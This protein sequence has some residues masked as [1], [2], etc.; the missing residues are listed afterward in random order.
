MIPKVNYTPKT[1]ANG[2][3]G[4]REKVIIRLCEAVNTLIETGGGSGT[5]PALFVDADGYICADY[6]NIPVRSGS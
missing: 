3:T 5:P 4:N 2:T 1:Y 6:D